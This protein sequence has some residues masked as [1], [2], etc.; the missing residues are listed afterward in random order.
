ME[1]LEMLETC[2]ELEWQAAVTDEK[3]EPE[4]QSVAP[5]GQQEKVK[6]RE[7][8]TDKIEPTEATVQSRDGEQ[9][10]EESVEARRVDGRA[11][12]AATP[13]VCHTHE[14]AIPIQETVEALDVTE[15]GERPTKRD[16]VPRD[17]SR[18]ARRPT[19]RL[20]SG[21]ETLLCYLELHPQQWVELLHPTL[22]TCQLM[23]YGGPQQLRKLTKMYVG[24]ARRAA[25]TIK[26]GQPGAGQWHTEA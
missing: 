24:E 13:R 22:S 6:G 17:I 14:R 15:E 7:E 4:H 20:S 23:C 11:E 2:D 25:S 16:A 18:G 21:I 10:K 8:E 9:I 12:K 3:M 19:N 26:R 5:D 1:M